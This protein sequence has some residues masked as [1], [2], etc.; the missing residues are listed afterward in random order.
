MSTRPRI[1]TSTRVL[2]NAGI[3]LVQAVNDE[4]GVLDWLVSVSWAPNSLG[5]YQA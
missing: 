2:V 1:L 4:D 3:T 5:L